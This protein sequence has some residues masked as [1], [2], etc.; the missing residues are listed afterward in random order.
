MGC[1]GAKQPPA[2]PTVV[3]QPVQHVEPTGGGG[4]NKGK[5]HK[6]QVK[7]G[8][9][10]KDY[11]EQEDRLLKRCYLIGNK[12]CKFTFRGVSYSY[13]FK[14]MTQTN[15]Q[16]HKTRDIRPPHKMRR[17]KEPLLPPCD[18]IVIQVKQG[19]PGKVIDVKNPHTG[20]F[21][22]VG[23][24]QNAKPGMKMAVPVP[25]KGESVEEIQSKQKGW[26]TGGR[27][28]AGMGVLAATGV[29]GVGGVLLGDYVAGGDM[30]EEAAGGVVDAAEVVGDAMGDVGEAIVDGC[31]DAIEWLGDAAED[32]G[33][34]VV[35][36]F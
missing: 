30:F 28:A 4:G 2:P 8:G 36:L 29:V 31:E 20:N 10:W 5:L 34:W 32:A 25:K 19:Q 16:S 13:D 3:A 18:S 22:K 33:D 24:P 17:P 11:D 12:N 6:F 7:L 26:T 9:E 23:V 14:K 35:S 21:I 15:E 1:G 27:V